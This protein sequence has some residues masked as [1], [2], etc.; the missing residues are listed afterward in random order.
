MVLATL[1]CLA[2][3]GVSG[4]MIA[5]P[6]GTSR[7]GPDAT[8]AIGLATGAFFA[9]CGLLAA[10]QVLQPARLT[11]EPAGL[12]YQWLW[13]R[14]MW[15]WREVGEFTVERV[16]S[17]RVIRFTLLP[18]DYVRPASLL[19]GGPRETI[20][21]GWRLGLEEVCS[22]LNAARDRWG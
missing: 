15:S 12:T 20:P 11:L 2:F 9:G 10:A 4:M 14:R 18:P 3:V 5:D 1:G 8:H 21:G 22:M 6:D 19:G 13:R 16:S 17:A 7:Y